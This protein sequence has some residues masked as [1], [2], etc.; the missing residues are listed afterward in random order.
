M[1]SLSRDHPRL[2]LGAAGPVDPIDLLLG[3]RADL[4]DLLLA[5]TPMD[6]LLLVDPLDP[7]CVDPLALS[8]AG[9]TILHQKAPAPHQP[10]RRVNVSASKADEGLQ[11]L[12]PCPATV[13]ERV[14]TG[15]GYRGLTGGENNYR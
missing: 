7:V 11:R 9:M 10:Q 14:I 12:L 4:V 3:N 2:L 13:K 5:L 8:Q 1:T 15:T 6:L